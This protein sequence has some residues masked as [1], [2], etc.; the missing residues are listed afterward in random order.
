M[1]FSKFS[2]FGDK[3]DSGRKQFLYNLLIS[4][5]DL[6]FDE[7]DPG[8]HCVEHLQ[9]KDGKR[10][11]LFGGNHNVIFFNILFLQHYLQYLISLY[12][13]LE[14]IQ[15]WTMWQRLNHQWSIIQ[16]CNWFKKNKR[17]FT[18]TESKRDILV[19]VYQAYYSYFVIRLRCD[20]YYRR[21]GQRRCKKNWSKIK[22]C[23]FFFL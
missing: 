15:I 11:L 10:Y 6:D 20:F 7:I 16:R 18:K 13:F 1:I 19:Q 12:K 5:T 23:V 3:I 8:F 17:Q 14:N 22:K 9:T 2:K 21:R 4:S